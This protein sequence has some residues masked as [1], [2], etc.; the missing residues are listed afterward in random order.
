MMLKTCARCHKP[1]EGSNRSKYC[2]ACSIEIKREA[3]R[4]YARK[5]RFEKQLEKLKE[6]EYV[7]V[8][9]LPQFEGESLMCAQIERKLLH[10]DF[11]NTE[12]LTQKEKYHIAN[13]DRCSKLWAKYGKVYEGVDLFH[14]ERKKRS[15][16]DIQQEAEHDLKIDFPDLT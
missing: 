4:N 2:D 15:K 10:G 9:D 7:K 14:G 13:C 12:P 16:E 6:K 5:K 11:W 1:Y 3:K 8:S